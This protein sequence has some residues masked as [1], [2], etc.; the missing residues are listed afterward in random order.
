MNGDETRFDDRAM[1]FLGVLAERVTELL[2]R[3][4][5]FPRGCCEA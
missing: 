1:Y 5:K 2:V 3:D 4:G